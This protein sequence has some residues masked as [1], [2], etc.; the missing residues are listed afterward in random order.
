[1]A[2]GAGCHFYSSH[3]PLAHRREAHVLKVK[4]VGFRQ[5]S[6]L[7]NL[8]LHPHRHSIDETH[9]RRHCSTLIGLVLMA[10]VAS[11]RHPTRTEATQDK[12]HKQSPGHAP[13][14]A[15]LCD[16]DSG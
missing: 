12:R 6:R 4:R 15:R 9:A 3:Q 8:A 7:T 11:A 13:H 2:I 16:D 10:D 14:D 5:R 1:L